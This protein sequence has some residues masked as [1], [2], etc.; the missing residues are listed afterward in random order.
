VNLI[1][2]G[3]DNVATRYLI[4]DAAVKLGKPWVYG[5]CVGVEGRVMAI[6]PPAGGPCLRCVFANPPAAGELPTCDTAGV[7]ASVAAIVASWQVVA[8]IQVLIGQPAEATRKML[9][10][11]GWRGDVRSMDLTT[12][13]QPDCPCC[14]R[15]KFEYLDTS[16]QTGATLCGR[17][18][19]QIR[20]PRATSLDLPA[21]ADRL[22]YAGGEVRLA[23]A[24]VRVGLPDNNLTLTAFADGRV[25]VQGTSDVARAKS[26]Y[27]RFV[28]G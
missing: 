8:A 28:G 11:D 12:A 7:L 6:D 13:R 3:T 18:A 16:P 21:L 9:S 22:Q 20:P 17:N 26:L 4:N 5:A 23:P 1:L 14:G 27:D 15:R 10:I 25:I 24:F 19:V 2:D